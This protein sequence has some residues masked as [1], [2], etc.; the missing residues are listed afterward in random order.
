MPTNQNSMLKTRKLRKVRGSNA[1]QPKQ[2]NWTRALLLGSAS[3]WGGYGASRTLGNKEPISRLS[4]KMGKL[5][6]EI[7]A[8]GESGKTSA[9]K[10]ELE[11]V[12]DE[13]DAKTTSAK[14]ESGITALLAMCLCIGALMVRRGIMNRRAYAVQ[15]EMQRHKNDF[16]ESVAY[17]EEKTAADLS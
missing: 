12:R 6:D 8:L 3:A 4:K 7:E 5:S 16:G 9:L 13:F 2:F 15:K 10:A 1:L 17:G 14:Q 11:A